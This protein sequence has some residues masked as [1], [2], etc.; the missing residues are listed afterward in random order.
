MDGHIKVGEGG[1]LASFTKPI[2]AKGIPVTNSLVVVSMEQIAQ[3]LRLAVSPNQLYNAMA[4]I[5]NPASYIVNGNVLRVISG[6]TAL[7][8]EIN[9]PYS[10][11]IGIGIGIGIEDPVKLIYNAK[12][13]HQIAG[14]SNLRLKS[15]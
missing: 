4:A 15:V 3:A 11:V 14:N 8:I 2:L 7:N 10:K 1:D 13:R 6:N 5:Q 12:E 9:A